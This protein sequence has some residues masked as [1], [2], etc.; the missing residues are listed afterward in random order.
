MNTLSKIIKNHQTVCWYP[1]AGADL[2]AVK[3]WDLGLGNK[4]KPTLFIKSD[5]AYFLNNNSS[6][7]YED[8]RGF[9]KIPE[10]FIVEKITEQNVLNC[11]ER[12]REWKEKGNN[13]LNIQN[14][15]INIGHYDSYKVL[16]EDDNIKGLCEIG[17]LDNDFI[18]NYLFEHYTADFNNVTYCHLKKDDVEIILLN[19]SNQ[20]FY[21]FCIKNSLK[22]DCL[23]LQSYM[24]CNL[25][26]NRCEKNV[27][28]TLQVREGIVNPSYTCYNLNSCNYASFNWKFYG[29]ERDRDQVAYLKYK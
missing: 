17:V 20:E 11:E 6:H 28:E 10:E 9:H 14:Q 23:I 4:L 15:A 26:E 8:V 27:V 19:A 29:D 18:F 1:S 5:I 12:L 21:N 22:I 16:I 25:F 2:N 24:E 7:F 13:I 3:Y